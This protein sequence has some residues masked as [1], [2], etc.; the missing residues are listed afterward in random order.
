MGGSLR[1]ELIMGEILSSYLHSGNGENGEN[2]E[3]THDVLE[4]VAYPYKIRQLSPAEK[5]NKS[6]SKTAAEAEL[7]FTS[8]NEAEKKN[9]NMEAF[10]KIKENWEKYKKTL[11][12]SKSWLSGTKYSK[13]LENYNYNEMGLGNLKTRMISWLKQGAPGTE[14]PTMVDTYPPV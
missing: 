6:G 11:V 13:V 12:V 2:G 4:K 5:E 7:F 10:N 9:Q 8:E 14:P 3:I 1:D